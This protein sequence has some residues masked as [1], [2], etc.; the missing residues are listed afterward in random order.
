MFSARRMSA[1]P[2][3]I[4]DLL[5][6]VA[7]APGARVLD[8][9]CG[10]GRHSIE[11]AT[12]GYRVTAVDRTRPYLDTARPSGGWKAAADRRHARWRTVAAA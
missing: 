2:G 11:L 4:D 5:A 6:L 9:C 3:E 12:R 8:L 1:A 7:L 10:P